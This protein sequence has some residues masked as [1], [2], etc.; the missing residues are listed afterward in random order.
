MSFIRRLMRVTAALALG[1]LILA[2]CA[3]R[4]PTTIRVLTYNIHHGEGLDKQ[5]DLQRI[6][7]LI[8]ESGADLVALQ[9]VDRDVPRTAHVDQ[10]AV[11]GELAGMHAVFEKNADMQGGD[12]G[13]AILTRWPVE[14]YANHLLPNFPHN[15]QRGLLEVHVRA[16][17]RTIAFFATHLDHQQDD[18]ERLASVAALRPLV[19][20]AGDDLVFVAGDLNATPETRVVADCTVF[21]HNADAAAREPLL[22]FPADTPDQKIDYVMYRPDDRIRCVAC[23]VLPE[24]VA[25]DHRP[26]LATFRVSR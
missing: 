23:R 17:N 10:P 16:G 7:D 4:S 3:D 13:N 15:E 6:A 18:G 11:L 9:E 20:A 12:Y 22:T 24:A 19:E 2:G 8:R 25:S 14:R 21:L 26:L 1:T 5:V